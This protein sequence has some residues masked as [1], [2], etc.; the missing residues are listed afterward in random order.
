MLGEDWYKFLAATNQRIVEVRNLIKDQQ[1]RITN[2]KQQG[3]STAD[4]VPRLR[5]LEDTVQQLAAR[6]ERILK[7]VRNYPL[8]VLDDGAVSLTGQNGMVE[9]QHR[10]DRVR[11][12]AIRGLTGDTVH[13]LHKSL[14]GIA[15][16]R[17]SIELTGVQLKR[18][19][20]AIRESDGLLER[21][22]K[23]GF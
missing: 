2:C 11:S 12:P 16:M 23:E 8:P 21:M 13:M 17:I 3:R 18:S 14:V 7:W 10:V 9:P 6:R 4:L 20:H 22:R 5:S 1:A 15:L 19:H